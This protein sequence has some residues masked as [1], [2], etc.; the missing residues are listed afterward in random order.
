MIKRLILTLL[1]IHLSISGAQCVCPVGSVTPV[2]TIE[3]Q[4]KTQLEPIKEYIHYGYT[5]TG[6]VISIKDELMFDECGELNDS[7]KMLL[8]V[9]AEIM[10]FSGRKWFILC[11]TT[12]GKTQVDR[13]SRTSLRAGEITNYL[14]DIE[15]CLINQIFPI[16][17]GSIMPTRNKTEGHQAL[18]NRVDFIIEEYS[19]NR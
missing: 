4:A 16:G 12:V 13:I 11:H 8:K 10:K 6:F 15:T 3:T 18:N 1:A 17:F 14:T 5:P 19:L 7:G 2:K 9:M